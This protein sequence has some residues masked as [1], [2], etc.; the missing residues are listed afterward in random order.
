MI[1][2]RNKNNKKRNKR[3]GRIRIRRVRGG[4]LGG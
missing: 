4:E 2:W 3:K 1:K